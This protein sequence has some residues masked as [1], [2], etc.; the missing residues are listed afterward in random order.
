MEAILHTLYDVISAGPND[1]R[2]WDRFRTLFVPSARLGAAVKIGDGSVHYFGLDVERYIALNDKAMSGKGFFEKEIHRHADT[3]G[4]M[5]QV[6][7]TYESRYKP[8]DPGPFERGIN[9]IQ[10]IDDGKRWWIVSIFWQSEDA[11]LTLPR[12]WLR[13]Q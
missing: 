10:L 3:F 5:T 6:F 9:S 13:G 1:K 7:S 8:D 2:D 4:N 11:L 12:S